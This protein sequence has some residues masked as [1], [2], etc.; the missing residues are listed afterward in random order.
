MKTRIFKKQD[1]SVIFSWPSSKYQGGTFVDDKSK[2]VYSEDNK[3]I[4]GY[5]QKE[6]T[7]SDCKFPEYSQGL[8]FIDVEESELNFLSK[9]SDNYF[10]MLHFEGECKIE[11]LKQD[12]TWE[13]YLMP[14]FLVK[15]K[16]IKSLNSL[17]EAEIA[18]ESSDA[19]ELFVL[20]NKKEIAK[21]L[22]PEVNEKELLEIA[23]AGL[24]RAQI[25]KPLIRKKLQARLDELTPSEDKKTKKK[26]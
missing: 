1:G 22:N 20:S 25:D 13:K 14:C 18:K 15:E 12:L 5:E 24:A 4:I 23:L 6:L 8:D 7:F 16:H 26:K 3:K 17:I 9:G 21:K 19:L 2:P 10:E 11:N